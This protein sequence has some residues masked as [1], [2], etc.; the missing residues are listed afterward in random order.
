MNCSYP[1]Y[2]KLASAATP[3]SCGRQ[4]ANVPTTVP[5]MNEMTGIEY[6]DEILC[7]DHAAE[8]A[9]WKMIQGLPTENAEEP[10]A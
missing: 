3:K 10:D 2:N 4:G 9:A 7:L 5:Y 8:V 1:I 6:R